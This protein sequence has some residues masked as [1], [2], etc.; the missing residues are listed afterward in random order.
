MKVGKGEV[1]PGG[2][3]SKAATFYSP[4]LSLAHRRGVVV[5][6]ESLRSSA[7]CE[8]GEERHDRDEADGRSKRGSYNRVEPE[9]TTE[10]G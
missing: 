10:R 5:E 2:T 6:D 7:E 3:A 8:E 4:P 9:N 1:G